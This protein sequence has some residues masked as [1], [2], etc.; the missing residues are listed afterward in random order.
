MRTIV[1]NL[2]EKV[3][4][5]KETSDTAVAAKIAVALQAGDPYA[6]HWYLQANGMIE[7]HKCGDIEWPIYAQKTKCTVHTNHPSN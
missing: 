1:K 6:H 3:R 7:C 2:I 4:K 5:L